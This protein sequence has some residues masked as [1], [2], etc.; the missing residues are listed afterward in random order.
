MKKINKLGA[1]LEL[2]LVF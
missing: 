2:F 1:Q